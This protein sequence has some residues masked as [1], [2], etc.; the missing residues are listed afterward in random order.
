MIADL[1]LVLMVRY[2]RV[3]S[4]LLLLRESLSIDIL[5]CLVA[6]LVVEV[7]VFLWWGHWWWYRSCRLLLL[8][9]LGDSCLGLL[10][11]WW[12]WL[13]SLWLCW[14]R[15]VGSRCKLRLRLL[16]LLLRWLLTILHWILGILV[17]MSNTIL[18]GNNS[19]ARHVLERGVCC[20]WTRNTSSRGTVLSQGY[21][22]TI[23]QWPCISGDGSFWRWRRGH[24][25]ACAQLLAWWRRGRFRGQGSLEAPSCITST[26]LVVPPGVSCVTW[27]TIGPSNTLVLDIS[28]DM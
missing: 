18:G 8:L 6:V 11:W 5:C 24:S 15:V 21:C 10:L 12:W 26:I 25:G 1:V 14:M 2:R 13:W 7:A 22:R 4:T 28:I 20:H 19:I 9:W 27:Y 3:A 23:L 17:S 16:L